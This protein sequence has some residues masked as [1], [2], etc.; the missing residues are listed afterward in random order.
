MH[1]TYITIHEE[2]GWFYTGKGTSEKVKSGSYMG[3]GVALNKAFT[4]YP[5]DEWKCSILW[6][7][8]SSDEAYSDEAGIVTNELLNDPK[9]LNL[10]LGG[11]GPGGNAY[12]FTS[13][14]HKNML[15]GQA[16]A[17]A[18]P[19]YIETR[20]SAGRKRNATLKKNPEAY[21]KWLEKQRHVWD[22]PKKKAEMIEKVR[23]SVKTAWARKR[24]EK[25]T[26]P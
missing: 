12:K 13:E 14:Q 1:C 3:T 15:E 18:K 23:E 6:E 26:C 20:R 7:F 8:E 2:T 19:G 16:A 25:Q 9:C 11:N 10:V 17:R 5:K 21:S 4:K 24:L 22:D